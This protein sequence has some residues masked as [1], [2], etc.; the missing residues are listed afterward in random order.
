MN[1]EQRQEDVIERNG[2]FY[3]RNREL[4][5]KSFLT[6]AAAEGFLLAYWHN[7]PEE[8]GNRH[9]YLCPHCGK[10]TDLSLSRSVASPPVRLTCEGPEDSGRGRDH[11]DCG[12][13][14]W[15]GRVHQLIRVELRV[16]PALPVEGGA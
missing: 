9:G 6:R 7:R 12:A 15:S 1:G 2:R 11:A 3:L 14:E 16:D 10:G 5:T 4:S 13:C 8:V